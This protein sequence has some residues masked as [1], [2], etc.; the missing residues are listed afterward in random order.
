MV[1]IAVPILLVLFLN[2]WLLIPSV[3][4][5]YLI[6][7]FTFYCTVLNHLVDRII[8]YWLPL[9]KDQEVSLHC[10]PL[11]GMVKIFHPRRKT[12]KLVTNWQRGHLFY[13]LIND[14]INIGIPRYTKGEV[15]GFIKQWRWKQQCLCLFNLSSPS[16]FLEVWMRLD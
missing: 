3:I 13:L 6:D 15:S 7:S 11:R 8:S 9:I 1:F 2:I 16:K 10:L 5:V 12:R 14:K 4:P